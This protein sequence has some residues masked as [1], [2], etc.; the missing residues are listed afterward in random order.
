V[1][2]RDFWSADARAVHRWFNT[3]AATE[4][5]VEQRE[6]FSEA[7]A[8]AW[9]QRAARN[10]GADRKWAVIVDDGEEA[11]GFTALYGVGRQAAPELGILIGDPEL[12]GKGVGTEAQ[13]L[14]IQRAFDELGAHRVTELILA[15][16]AAARKV[17][18]RLGFELEGM[19]PGHVR[20]GERLLDV[21]I[22]GVTP[23][24]FKG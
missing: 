1:G 15:Q 11:V 2:L 8:G 23:K 10:E 20:R 16:N 22:Y 7:E 24:G 14:T 4:G 13:K 18:E 5:L 12:W 9:V 17:V 6:S 3:A 21:A 19:M